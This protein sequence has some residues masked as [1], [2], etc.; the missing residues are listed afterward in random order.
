MVATTRNS[1]K[2]VRRPRCKNCKKQFRTTSATKVYCSPVCSRHVANAKRPKVDRIEK[3]RRSAPFYRLALEV[4]RAGTLEILRGHTAESLLALF[5]LQS[6]AFEFNGYGQQRLYELS[7]VAPAN[8]RHIVGLYVAENLVIAPRGLNNAHGTSHYGNHGVWIARTSLNP[9]HNV[10]ERERDS[11]VLDRILAYLGDDLV[12]EVVKRGNIQPMQRFKLLAWLEAFIEA[13]PE[14]SH[15]SENLA[16]MSTVALGKL[17][18]QLQCK[19]VKAFRLI[20][21]EVH[22]LEMLSLELSRHA[23]LRPSLKPLASFI[24]ECVSHINHRE[25]YLIESPL[26]QLLFNVLMGLELED[27]ASELMPVLETLKAMI[28][29][30][31][32]VPVLATP[33]VANAPVIVLK[34]FQSFADEVDHDMHGDTLSD[35]PVM[36]LSRPEPVCDDPVPW[37]QPT[38]YGL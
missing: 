29:I 2:A 36:L 11:D 10:H 23:E 18:S 28:K 7:H 33:V 1:N 15:H 17:K 22:P 5:K 34:R 35:A 21:R 6:Q 4:K 20:T 13:H 3:A 8:G 38:A 27:V 9:K 32:P 25:P 30:A 19:D 31:Q 16:A 24:A 12:N 26:L 14:H 37:N